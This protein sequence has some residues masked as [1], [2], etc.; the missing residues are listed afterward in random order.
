MLDLSKMPV[1]G[2][3]EALVLFCVAFLA[4]VAVVGLR[5]TRRGRSRFWAGPGVVALILLPA[6]LG[7]GFTAFE[8]RAFLSTFAAVSSPGPAA[9]AGA[10][11]DALVPLLAGLLAAAL[12]AFV[13]LLVIAVGSSS[14]KVGDSETGAGGQAVA[15][16]ALSLV[17]GLAL[18]IVR[19]IA[20]AAGAEQYLPESSLKVSLSLL[21]SAVLATFLA[22]VVLFNALRAPRGSAPG[23]VKMMSVSAISLCGLSTLGGLWG[24][25]GERRCYLT[26]MA[27]GQPCDA[28]AAPDP[29]AEAR[30]ESTAPPAPVESVAPVASPEPPPPL[31]TPSLPP[32][33]KPRPAP[34]RATP[35]ALREMP[36]RAER[37]A[38]PST[39]AP[40]APKEPPAPVRVGGPIKEPRKIKNVAPRYPQVA[41]QSKIQGIIIIE[42][43]IGPEGD[44]TQATVL[45]GLPLLDQAALDAVKQW[46]YAPTLVD[47]VPVPVIM[48]V[49]INFRLR[50]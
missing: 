34:A 8:F 41:I 45:R 26:T 28:T 18:L 6:A 4:F 14:E 16:V 37:E 3:V 17:T 36:R 20:E 9:R 32:S 24:V 42:C 33:P 1:S 40:P 27:T 13:G 2:L 11:A 35:P 21:G 5:L 46:V 25:Q 23:F 44:V 38:T 12:L 48:T 19:T 30:V 7:A 47:G 22:M 10:A 39:A 49:T 29:V 15:L 50:Q 43:T 31:P